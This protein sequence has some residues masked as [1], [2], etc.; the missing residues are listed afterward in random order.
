MKP[1][2]P[3]K[4]GK[5]DQRICWWALI[6][7][8]QMFGVIFGLLTKVMRP[9]IPGA[10]LP[11][12]GI[13]DFTLGNAT[14]MQM[15]MAL[16]A[17][18]LGFASFGTGLTVVQMKRMDGPGP[19]LAY[20]YMAA[21]A[22]AALPGC[23][24][25]GLSFAASVF[26]PD[27][28]PQLIAFL[29]EMGF[30]GFI[31]CMGCFAVQYIVFATAIFLDRRGIFPKWLGYMTVWNLVTELLAAPV[32]I[33]REGFYSWNGLISFY[34]GTLLF[35]IW[36]VCLITFLGKNITSQPLSELNPVYVARLRA[37]GLVT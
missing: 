2:K 14:N 8:Y 22:V 23:Y 1:A 21:G 26:R 32:W 5:L 24:L 12:N 4:I 34:L 29:Y 16:L 31:G 27:R 7:F 35:V 25:C 19:V 20:A 10:S 15:G 6:G 11:L 36:L 30:I 13:L 17:I 33:F 3:A 28:D 18:F 37:K 9:P